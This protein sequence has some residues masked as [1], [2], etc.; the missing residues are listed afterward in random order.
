MYARRPLNNAQQAGDL[1]LTALIRI[2]RTAI[3]AI[4]FYY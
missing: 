2:F 3:D 4:L 1:S